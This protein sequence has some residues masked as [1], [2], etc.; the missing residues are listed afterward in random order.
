MGPIATAVLP[1][2][3]PR[4]MNLGESAAQNI[5]QPISVAV[6]N[7]GSAPIN[8]ATCG[9]NKLANKIFGNSSSP[10]QQFTFQPQQRNFN[11]PNQ[12]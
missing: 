7:L 2:L 8:I 11:F 5:L 9:L 1:Q 6:G 10:L 3:L 4:A 12:N